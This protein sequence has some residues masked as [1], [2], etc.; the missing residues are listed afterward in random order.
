MTNALGQLLIFIAIGV[1]WR[2]VKPL[3]INAGTM[4]RNLFG[5]QNGCART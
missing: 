1:A 4:Q 2:Y 5:L 3:G